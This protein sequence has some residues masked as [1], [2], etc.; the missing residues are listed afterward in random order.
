MY[1]LGYEYA[2]ALHRDGKF[3]AYHLGEVLLQGVDHGV[4]QVLV[5]EVGVLRGSAAKSVGLQGN[6]PRVP[7]GWNT[8]S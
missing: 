7:A 2:G 6:G 5:P 8:R 1:R 3:D 4:Q